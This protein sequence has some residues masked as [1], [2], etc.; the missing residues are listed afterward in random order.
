MVEQTTYRA[1]GQVASGNPDALKNVQVDFAAEAR[2]SDGMAND[3]TW[4]TQAVR[5]LFKRAT[6]SLKQQIDDVARLPA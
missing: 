3:F 1:L 2:Q 5:A 6:D 4:A